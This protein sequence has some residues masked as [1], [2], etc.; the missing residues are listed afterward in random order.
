MASLTIGQRMR[1][2]T[3][4]GASLQERAVLPMVSAA[5]TTAV[6]VA[7]LVPALLI[8]TSFMMGTGFMKC[9][10]MTFSGRCVEAAMVVMEMDEV[11]DARMVSGLHSLSS[12]VKISASPIGSRGPLPPRGRNLRTGFGPCPW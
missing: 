6:L 3:K 1:F 11:L 4:P 5:S 2:E 8:P 9:I 10:P 12:S 7:S